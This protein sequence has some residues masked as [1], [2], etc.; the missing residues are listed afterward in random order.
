[1]KRETEPD[2]LTPEQLQE[3]ARGLYRL[4]DRWERGEVRLEAGTATFDG[5]RLTADAVFGEVTGG[6]RRRRSPRPG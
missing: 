1:M 4:A 2:G 5:L 6:F 3:I